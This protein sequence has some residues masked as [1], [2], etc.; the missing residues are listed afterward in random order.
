MD[1]VMG[2]FLKKEEVKDEQGI[3]KGIKKP[4]KGGFFGIFDNDDDELGECLIKADTCQTNLKYNQE[5]LKKHKNNYQF[6]HI[7]KDGV[8]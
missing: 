2:I 7:M 4:K 5:N 6:H 1:K 8:S 3:E